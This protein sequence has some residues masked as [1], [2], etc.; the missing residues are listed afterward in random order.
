MDEGRIAELE[1]RVLALLDQERAQSAEIAMLRTLL[2]LV[3][4]DQRAPLELQRRFM[5]ATSQ[6]VMKDLVSGADPT[7]R[8][9]LELAAQSYREL[10]RIAAASPGSP[11]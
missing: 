7:L 10:L 1:H 2:L 5:E 3:V 8:K 6:Y 9:Q 4:T 11:E